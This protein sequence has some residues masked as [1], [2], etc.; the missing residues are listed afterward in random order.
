MTWELF[1]KL[2]QQMAAG[3]AASVISPLQ[4]LRRS[5][6]EP[7]LATVLA[8]AL[9]HCGR[10]GEALVALQTDIAQGIDNHWTHYCLGH[11]LAARGKLQDAAACFR[12]CH[13][14]QGWKDSEERRYTFTHDYFSGHISDWQ[15]WFH[16]FITKAPIHIL[17]I[18][19]WQGG[20]TLW[21]LDHVIGPRGGTI[22]CVDTWE[23]SSE[24][25]FLSSLGLSLEELFDAN[26]ART[27]KSEQ[28]RKHK[29][30]S[31]DILPELPP[32]CFDLIYI[33]GAH[34][35]QSVIQDAIHAHRLLAPGGFLL[36]DDLDYCFADSNQNTARAINFFTSTFSNEYHEC[37]RTSQ[38]L[39]QKRRRSDLPERLLFVLGMHRSGTSALSGLLCHQGFTPPASPISA[40]ANNPTGYWEPPEICEVHNQLLEH[41]QSSW[42]DL[43]LPAELWAPQEIDRHLQQLEVALKR[44]F[45]LLQSSQIALVKDPRQCRLQP[46]W[47]A[48]IHKHQLKASALLVARHP[49]AVARSLKRR[50]QLPLNR[51]L[52]LWLAHTLEA[53]RHSRI[54]E[55][56][57]VIY[58]LLLQNPQA[59]L[60][61][62]QYLAGLQMSNNCD[63]EIQQF[64]RPDLNHHSNDQYSHRS[65]ELEADRGLLRLTL[66][67]YA[68]L[69]MAHGHT[70]S[71]EDQLYFDQSHSEL[72]ERLD[73]LA[74]QSSRLEL[75]QVFWE[76]AAGGGFSEDQSLRHSVLVGKGLNRAEMVL[77]VAATAARALRLDPAEQPSVI[78][79]QELA[80]KS[81][82]GEILWRWLAQDT[83][84]KRPFTAVND[85]CGFLDDGQLVAAT[86]DPGLLLHIPAS[87]LNQISEGSSLY[88]EANWQA[89]QAQLARRL[90]LATPQARPEDIE[91]D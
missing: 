49:L 73:A 11:H 85:Q 25:T 20:S 71:E 80:L 5:W 57:V 53:E 18:G 6:P 58:E 31:H 32:S 70:I 75:L 65:E 3:E 90:L 89:L 30:S 83:S 17:E 82:N 60:L 81:A 8:D 69:V 62:C 48:L 7:A 39:L 64:I 9:M 1:E 21:M 84:A 43:M 77:P 56:R 14:L 66:D 12:R 67:V 87:A 47:N 74:E 91:S 61:S 22:T 23:G 72:T 19:S 15:D 78:A 27:G 34:E 24:H 16:R 2:K 42:D 40:D 44:D 38:L 63:V 68:R 50:D 52:L 28:V 88:I 59:T 29:G 33:D 54:I 10:P 35:A 26:V 55:R 46:L 45:P 37:A 76:P 41:L 36:F 79:L 4:E 86:H 51:A 13:S